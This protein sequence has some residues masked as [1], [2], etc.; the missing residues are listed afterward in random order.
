MNWFSEQ[1]SHLSNLWKSYVSSDHEDNVA[2]V[3]FARS[4]L[5]TFD[6]NKQNFRNLEGHPTDVVVYCCSLLLDFFVL[7][8]G[9]N[10]TTMYQHLLVRKEE[11]Q[12]NEQIFLAGCYADSYSGSTTQIEN[13]RDNLLSMRKYFL[14]VVHTVSM[15]TRW[16]HNRQIIFA[17]LGKAFYHSIFKIVK[18]MIKRVEDLI[19]SW[20]DNDQ[21]SSEMLEALLEDTSFTSS[22]IIG[23]VQICGKEGNIHH[24]L[25]S[26]FRMKQ[27][28]E[29]S[30]D[31]ADY[32]RI[33]IDVTYDFYTRAV[34]DQHIGVDV[35]SRIP[36]RMNALDN[37][38]DERQLHS[39]DFDEGV[40][41]LVSLNSKLIHL[42]RAVDLETS[43]PN[44]MVCFSERLS[45]KTIRKSIIMMQNEVLF[46]LSSIVLMQPATVKQLYYCNG[47]SSI[48]NTMSSV[49]LLDKKLSPTSRLS[50]SEAECPLLVTKIMLCLQLQEAAVAASLRQPVEKSEVFDDL[51]CSI[52]SLDKIME[53]LVALV[54]AQAAHHNLALDEQTVAITYPSKLRANLNNIDL[55]PWSS[56][57]EESSRLRNIVLQGNL[58]WENSDVHTVALTGS[59]GSYWSQRPRSGTISHVSELVDHSK[60]LVYALLRIKCLHSSAVCYNDVLETDTELHSIFNIPAGKYINHLF[61][62]LYDVAWKPGGQS[63]STGTSDIP[64]NP[65][66]LVPDATALLLKDIFSV[67]T[68]PASSRVDT[69]GAILLQI[70]YGIFLARSMAKSFRITTNVLQ[71][72]GFLRRMLKS[73]RVSSFSKDD[74]DPFSL[75]NNKFFA[76]SSE[77]INDVDVTT[78]TWSAKN[79]QSFSDKQDVVPRNYKKFEVLRERLS[80]HHSDTFS[81]DVVHDDTA[82]VDTLTETE[83]KK[84]FSQSMNETSFNMSTRN[85]SFDSADIGSDRSNAVAQ[86]IGLSSPSRE[87]DGIADLCDD[88]CSAGM[89]SSVTEDFFTTDASNFD[90]IFLRSL[91]KDINLEIVWLM[92]TTKFAIDSTTEEKST[93]VMNEQLLNEVV[94]AL[95]GASSDESIIQ[96][97]RWLMNIIDFS[98][99]NRGYITS[100]IWSRILRTCLQ[101]CKRQIEANS[102]NCPRTDQ[103]LRWPARVTILQ[104][105]TKILFN[106]EKQTWLET[107]IPQVM[108]D[109]DFK[110]LMKGQHANSSR[111]TRSASVSIGNFATDRVRARQ[112]TMSTVGP[113]M[114]I[115]KQSRHYV[116]LRMVMDRGCRVYGTIF[117]MKILYECCHERKKESN[118][119]E[120]VVDT[121]T[122]KSSNMASVYQ[123]LAHDIIKGILS[124]IRN[125]HQYCDCEDSFDVVNL[126]VGMLKILIRCPELFSTDDA[127]ILAL[128]S[129]QEIFSSYGVP[130]AAHRIFGWN[131][132]R[133]NIYRDTL[134]S[135]EM[136]LNMASDGSPN[137]RSE[138]VFQT[139]S[140][141]NAIMIGNEVN[142]E[143]F[144][145][146]MVTR[147][148]RKANGVGSSGLSNYQEFMLMLLSTKTPDGFMPPVLVLI[149]LETMVDG[150]TAE[151]KN[152]TL[153]P[154]LQNNFVLPRSGFYHQSDK[155]PILHNINGLQILINLLPHFTFNDQFC[156]LE[157][158]NNFVA[159]SSGNCR[160]INLSKFVSA[161][162]TVFDLVLD[163][164][165]LLNPEIQE[166]CVQLL[167]SIGRH[168][169]TVSQLKRIFRLMRLKDARRPM[170]TWYLLDAL[171]GMISEEK[172]PKNFFFFHG[173]DSGM[174]LPAFKRWPA[175]KGYSFSTWFCVDYPTETNSCGN[176]SRENSEKKT[177]YYPRILSFRQENG[178]GIEIALHPHS[179]MVNTFSIVIISHVLI[180]STVSTAQT[181][182]IGTT[183][184]AGYSRFS[185]HHIGVSH[186]PAGFRNK[187]EMLVVID[188]ESSRH[189]IPFPR[190]SEEVKYPT[191]GDVAPSFQEDSVRSAFCGLMSAVYFFS[192]PLQEAYL[193][194]IFSL[195]PQYAG[196]FSDKD[197]VFATESNSRTSKALDGSLT[198]LI[199]LA[200][201]PGVYKGN[202]LIDNSPEQNV[203]NWKPV[204]FAEKF[205]KS[206]DTSDF[207]ALDSTKSMHARKLSGLYICSS[208]EMRDSLDC[209]GGVKVLLPLFSQ[210]GVSKSNS[211][212]KLRHIDEKELFLKVLKLFF[213]VFRDTPENYRFIT[214]MGFRLLAH[215]IDKLSP[216]FITIEVLD[217]L[218]LHCEWLSFNQSWQDE[219]YRYI[220][221]NFKLWIFAPF[222]VQRKLLD[223]LLAFTSSNTTRACNIIGVRKLLDA[224]YL[225]YSSSALQRSSTPKN[226]NED[227]YFYRQWLSFY[228]LQEEELAELRQMLQQMIGVMILSMKGSMDDD[229]YGVLKYIT[230]ETLP[231]YKIEGLQLFLRLIS[232]EK[233]EQSKIVLSAICNKKGLM[234]VVAMIDQPRTKVRL[235]ALICVCSILH[236]ALTVG[237]LPVPNKTG[238][239]GSATPM[240][241]ASSSDFAATAI[242]RVSSFSDVTS[243]TSPASSMLLSPGSSKSTQSKRDGGDVSDADIIDDSNRTP[244]SQD[245]FESLGVPVASLGNFFL[246]IVTTLRTQILSG[247][248][249]DDYIDEQCQVAFHILLLTMHGQ[250]CKHLVND[251]E[252]INSKILLN[253]NKDL[254]GIQEIK[255]HG[256]GLENHRMCFPMLLHSLLDLLKCETCSPGLRMNLLLQI[257]ASVHGLDNTDAMLSL[258]TWQ[259]PF[260]HLLTA[261]QVYLN[262]LENMAAVSPRDSSGGRRASIEQNILFSK[263][264]FEIIKCMFTEVHIHAVRY[265]ISQVPKYIVA[266]PMEIDV[267]NYVNKMPTKQYI[268]FLK[269]DTRMLGS[270]GKITHF[271][272][273]EI[274]HEQFLNFLVILETISCLRSLEESGDFDINRLGLELLQQ[275]VDLLQRESHSFDHLKLEA[276]E[277]ALR[278]RIFEINMWIIAAVVLEYITLPPLQRANIK[279]TRSATQVIDESFPSFPAFYDRTLSAPVERATS[280]TINPLKS[281]KSHQLS[282]PMSMNSM[283]NDESVAGIDRLVDSSYEKDSVLDVLQSYEP[284][285]SVALS[286]AKPSLAATMG[287]APHDIPK[288]SLQQPDSSVNLF[289][290]SKGVS[291]NFTISSSSYN[292]DHDTTIWHLLETLLDLIGPMDQIAK[293]WQ[294]L[295]YQ[296][297]IKIMMKL[298]ISSTRSLKKQL[299]GSL[300][301]FI[302]PSF[303][304]KESTPSRVSQKSKS[305][306]QAESLYSKAV[307]NVFWILVRTLLDIFVR[308]SSDATVVESSSPALLAMDRLLSIFDS[309]KENS[310]DFFDSE[311]LYVVAKITAAIPKSLQMNNSPWTIKALQS[312]SKL[313]IDQRSVLKQ[314]MQ[315]FVEPRSTESHSDNLY[316]Y[317]ENKPIVDAALALSS[318]GLVANDLLELA[319]C[320]ISLMCCDRVES[321]LPISIIAEEILRIVLQLPSD[322]TFHWDI[323][324]SGM[325]PVLD[326]AKKAEDASLAS[327][328]TELG[329]HKHSQVIRKLVDTQANARDTYFYH[330]S[331]AVDEAVSKIRLSESKHLRECIKTEENLRK[332]NISD[333]DK[334]FEEICN[335]R[336]PW[337]SGYE[338]GEENNVS[339]QLFYSYNK[340]KQMK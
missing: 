88:T 112:A 251:I 313:L 182:V 279:R 271:R 17:H 181:T 167:Q 240:Q 340:R 163:V 188:G 241:Y 172:S 197:D 39:S 206:D 338:V 317:L 10:T 102:P 178:I 85:N 96:L 120:L 267:E 248:Y 60:A 82:S 227:S 145:Q 185:W 260:F 258:P 232:P 2:F 148:R 169:I 262:N 283:K 69:E 270:S 68:K 328:L 282:S 38:A 122:G 299:E 30:W 288:L 275:T 52:V 305:T 207:T 152:T 15:L 31:P 293:A 9:T 319:Y 1:N 192:D 179:T 100:A 173:Y 226:K 58:D 200:F 235:Y 231:D 48:H 54:T 59:S 199:M 284:Q 138:V 263:N 98:Q 49:D 216:R 78:A 292:D 116:L 151:F 134:M 174:R 161:Q 277:T 246:W 79:S 323:W 40:E 300:D 18:S 237:K 124:T 143:L 73:S 131:H 158:I 121:K 154:L 132:S 76:Q 269:R 70:Y 201:N 153:L 156:V 175:S 155:P 294:Q 202:L 184:I 195:G 14:H 21:Q 20:S 171:E 164:F 27:I 61:I 208:Q 296:D 225:V 34:E 256:E 212:L 65:N 318:E 250:S 3:A 198:P 110:P 191:I 303:A 290:P 6:R 62:V 75:Q 4:F 135:V 162:P 32:L 146:C 81:S 333:W 117:L 105:I 315:Q 170:Y 311:S 95:H 150:F 255:D 190:F 257:K 177:E 230:H 332:K 336:G 47:S 126:L 298:G 56:A 219:F 115:S 118:N 322:G 286:S 55:Y 210:L 249:D 324:C 268:E 137:K 236:L 28:P 83:R 90:F 329:L 221:G 67:V 278:Q 254:E 129:Y 261:E 233:Q 243:L 45:I 46:A 107:F 111:G 160:W 183:S 119:G 321:R 42:F 209:L 325:E 74:L 29:L 335:D 280:P 91:L 142:K 130:A 99:Y 44:L 168:T 302:S 266:K 93:L 13:F 214:D 36:R 247:N 140:F 136:A 273:S 166:K 125:V 309:L 8:I 295:D 147:T 274:F 234:M 94:E 165:P 217:A 128:N 215:A 245:I 331:L 33:G 259:L 193:A 239:Q 196:L 189:A 80:S 224:L 43:E 108:Q 101:W 205:S 141:F 244:T 213:S 211:E 265:G 11:I 314:K 53:Y 186:S 194:G 86:S 26:K 276:Y 77:K 92:C 103:P 41:A 71:G 334:V 326:E 66:G 127:N 316:E 203:N 114:P 22:A 312:I 24:Q 301:S 23:L 113:N 133:P 252:Q 63:G 337:G 242:Q 84:S 228:S 57:E 123:A 37:S 281:I 297:R 149:L 187:S 204:G 144:R 7:D 97:S 180:K 223:Y 306:I 104:L 320:Q 238:K 218:L 308:A 264:I 253:R 51:R 229:V 176:M 327:K 19:V 159:S 220:F 272:L 330:T 87:Y 304:S 310:K 72:G 5:Q 89:D 285:E 106:G 222:Q 291:T 35:G 50:I 25:T 157:T 339:V 307:N 139:I 16:S 64:S 109:T 289:V 12:H 287:A